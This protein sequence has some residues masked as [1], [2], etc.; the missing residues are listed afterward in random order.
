MGTYLHGVREA[1]TALEE[2]AGQDIDLD[3]IELTSLKPLD[4]DTIRM[5]LQRTHKIALLDESTTSGGVG[6]TVSALISEHCFD[7]LD[8][9]VKRLSMD[10]A[11]VPYAGSMEE[12]VVKRSTDLVAAVIDL[13]QQRV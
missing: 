13:V 3:L 9:P 6:A 7:E 8:A 1:Q 11:P 12:A 2:L 5:S 10:D 4:I